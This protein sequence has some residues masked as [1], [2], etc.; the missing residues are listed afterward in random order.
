MFAETPQDKSPKTLLKKNYISKSQRNNFYGYKCMSNYTNPFG[1]HIF[2]QSLWN[3]NVVCCLIQF[4]TL[5]K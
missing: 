2:A 1:D 3:K 4:G 5:E